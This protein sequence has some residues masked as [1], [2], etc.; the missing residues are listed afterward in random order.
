MIIDR[1]DQNNPG[2]LSGR[3]GADCKQVKEAINQNIGNAVQAA[4]TFVGGVGVGFYYGWEL[5]LLM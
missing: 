2:K 1:Y 3:L 4:S 5:T